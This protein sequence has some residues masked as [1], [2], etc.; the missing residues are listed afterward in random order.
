MCGLLLQLQ[1]CVGA[2]DGC[3]ALLI[4]QGYLCVHVGLTG[5]VYRHGCRLVGGVHRCTVSGGPQAP[6]CIK[7]RSVKPWSGQRVGAAHRYTFRLGLDRVARDGSPGPHLPCGLCL[8]TSQ[9]DVCKP[10]CDAPS[11]RRASQPTAAFVAGRGCGRS[12]AAIRCWRCCGSCLE[13]LM[14]SSATA[15]GRHHSTNRTGVSCARSCVSTRAAFS[16]RGRHEAPWELCCVWLCVC[17]LLLCTACWQ[18]RTVH[19][20]CACLLCILL[21]KVMLIDRCTFLCLW[22][23]GRSGPPRL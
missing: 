19:C 17:V 20:V 11:L 13:P 2:R 16:T 10:T 6:P 8:C 4:C 21:L 23:G 3:V 12:G 14:F 5:C 22:V 18:P 1:C 9:C 15:M 7:A